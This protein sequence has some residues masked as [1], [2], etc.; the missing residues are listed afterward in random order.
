MHEDIEQ[1]L[2]AAIFIDPDTAHLRTEWIKTNSEKMACYERI[3]QEY[4]EIRSKFYQIQN[5]PEPEH[6]VK[7]DAHLK[8]ILLKEELDAGRGSGGRSFFGNCRR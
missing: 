8:S 6:A 3:K 1:V 2:E 4:Y 7:N 5:Y